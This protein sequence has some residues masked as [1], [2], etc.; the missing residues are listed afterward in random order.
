M[1]PAFLNLLLPLS[2]ETSEQG[3]TGLM[4]CFLIL[5]EMKDALDRIL[6]D[7]GTKGESSCNRVTYSILPGL[8][9][10]AVNND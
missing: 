5:C 3:H 8:W 4:W 2:L 7:Y 1:F 9:S 6:W 10:G